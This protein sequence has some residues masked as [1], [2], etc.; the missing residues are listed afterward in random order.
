VR[1]LE[2]RVPLRLAPWVERPVP[3][4]PCLCDVWHDHVLFEG[5]AVSGIV[6]YGS[7]KMDHVAV[8][9]ARLL[10]SL[11]DGG[12]ELLDAYDRVRPLS[13]EERELIAVLEETGTIIGAANWL[14]W[15]YRDGTR[16]DDLDGVAQRLGSLVTRLQR[17]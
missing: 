3:L 13:S 4:Q 7:V 2:Q 14:R 10:G 5:A 11:S 9:L 8:D 17:W 16:Y 6:D 12:R 15:L 1:R